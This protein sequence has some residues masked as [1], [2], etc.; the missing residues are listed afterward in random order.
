MSETQRT[1]TSAAVLVLLKKQ[2]SG[3]EVL[4]M[5][6]SATVKT[7]QSQVAFPGGGTEPHDENDPVKTALRE[8]FEEVG[9]PP[10]MVNVM[11]TLPPLP[12]LTSGFFVHPVLGELN[13]EK[14]PELN[15]VLDPNEV[16][17]AE[18]VSIE[19]LFQSKRVENGF[20]VFDWHGL[21][22]K[23]RKVWGLTAIILELIFNSDTKTL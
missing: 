3:A 15:L 19:T 9:V 5:E 2:D 22:Q 16:A 10:A 4:L 20:P 21:D 6:R 11:K 12:T 14:L 7:H 1:R 23:K 18:W 8:C 17:Y 13:P